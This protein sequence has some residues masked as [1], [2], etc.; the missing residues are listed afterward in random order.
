MNKMSVYTIYDKMAR[1]SGPLFESYNNET[2]IRTFHNIFKDNK[3]TSPE[4]FELW[5]VGEFDRDNIQLFLF[6]EKINTG[7]KNE[8]HIF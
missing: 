2:A 8:E 5:K 7:D 6:Q 4:D 1:L 3:I